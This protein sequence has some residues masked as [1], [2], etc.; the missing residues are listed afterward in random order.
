MGGDATRDLAATLVGGSTT[1]GNMTLSASYGLSR[2]RSSMMWPAAGGGQEGTHGGQHYR[3]G[4]VRPEPDP[5]NCSVDAQS[6]RRT[7]QFPSTLLGGSL[8]T[9]RATYSIFPM[10][11]RRLVVPSFRVIRFDFCFEDNA[12]GCAKRPVRA[13]VR[14]K[15]VLFYSCVGAWRRCRRTTRRWR[16]VP[17]AYGSRSVQKDEQWSPTRDSWRQWPLPHATDV[18]CRAWTRSHVS[19][20]WTLR[21]S[22]NVRRGTWQRRQ[23]TKAHDGSLKGGHEHVGIS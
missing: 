9:P 6:W 23:G 7:N 11:E 22:W 10:G 8:V 17:D 15:K 20:E 13:R 2:H 4:V 21:R 16:V 18:Q 14:S 19:W 3:S 5:Y 1:R 12:Y